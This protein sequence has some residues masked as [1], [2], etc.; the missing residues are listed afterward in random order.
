MTRKSV[1]DERRVSLILMLSATGKTTAARAL[2]GEAAV[3]DVD[4]ARVPSTDPFLKLGRRVQLWSVH[5]ALWHAQIAGA[6]GALLIRHGAVMVFDHTG[7]PFEDFALWSCVAEV[8]VV[9]PDSVDE[10]AK[11]FVARGLERGKHLEEFGYGS[12]SEEE[13]LGRVRKMLES[14]AAARSALLRRVPAGVQK[15]VMPMR[16]VWR[17]PSNALLRR[18]SLSKRLIAAP[19]LHSL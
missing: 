17:D 15:R 9:E 4:D 10:A 8:V 14:Q 2:R 16:E 1:W 11:R 6:L 7:W 18:S 5:N 19:R 13:L 3:F 12:V